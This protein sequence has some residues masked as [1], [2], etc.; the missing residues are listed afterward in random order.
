MVELI[1]F[2]LL[3][4]VSPCH[5]HSL[6]QEDIYVCPSSS[7]VLFLS[8][9]PLCLSHIISLFMYFHRIGRLCTLL[10]DDSEQ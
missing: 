7:F 3:V 5:P 9:S 8:L 10:N 6:G 1:K 2:F 4:E